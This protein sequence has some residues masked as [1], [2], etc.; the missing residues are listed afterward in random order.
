MITVC[1]SHFIHEETFHLHLLEPLSPSHFLF[2]SLLLPASCHSQMIQSELNLHWTGL[3]VTDGELRTSA[4][5]NRLRLHRLSVLRGVASIFSLSPGDE[6]AAE[7]CRPTSRTLSNVHFHIFLTFCIHCGAVH[8]SQL[9]PRNNKQ[10]KERKKETL[11]GKDEGVNQFNS[12][13]WTFC[14]SSVCNVVP[15]AGIPLAEKHSRYS[16]NQ[17][18]T[19]YCSCGGRKGQWCLTSL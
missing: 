3:E 5:T 17:K 16:Q 12:Q 15:V 7:L 8:A 14:V 4:D 10:K 6:L 1:H 13:L 18:N 19:K 9:Q 11:R 2:I